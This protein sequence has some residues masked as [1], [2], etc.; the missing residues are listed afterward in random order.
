MFSCITSN[1]SAKKRWQNAL[2]EEV[3]PTDGSPVPLYYSISILCGLFLEI[4][5]S[6]KTERHI[7]KQQLKVQNPSAL[8]AEA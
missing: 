5:N 8:T 6:L 4:M 3:H 1:F 2:N 7:G